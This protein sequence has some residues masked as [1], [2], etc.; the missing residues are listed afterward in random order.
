MVQTGYVPLRSCWPE[1]GGGGPDREGEGHGL[2]GEAPASLLRE[3]GSCAPEGDPGLTLEPGW[4][5]LPPL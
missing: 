2:L 3:V 5:L 1:G 4:Y